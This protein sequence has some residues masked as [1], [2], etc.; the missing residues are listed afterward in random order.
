MVSY[1]VATFIILLNCSRS[2]IKDDRL[3]PFQSICHWGADNQRSG[4]A[5]ADFPSRP[6]L[7]WTYKTTAAV[8]RAITAAD[9]FLFLGTK[10]GRVTVLDVRT[11]KSVRSLS[12]K[13][14]IETTCLIG[15]QYLIVL[16]RTENPT[17]RYINLTSGKTIWK[18][19]AGNIDG[20]P[21]LIRNK[22]IIGNAV[23]QMMAI[24]IQTGD[25]LWEKTINGQI[26]NSMAEYK[27]ALFVA[28]DNGHI[29]SI[30]S[31]NGD[32][33]W[34]NV[35]EKSIAATPVLDDNQMYIG[36]R[37]GTFYALSQSDGTIQWECEAKGGIYQTAAVAENRVYFGTT[38]GVLYCLDCT[39]GSP[40]WQ[41]DTKSVIGTSPLITNQ[42]VI[43]GTLDRILVML[44]R[45][46]GEMVWQMEARG[47]IRTTPLIWKNRLIFASEDRYIYGLGE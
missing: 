29:W 23:G 30:N 20:E 22:M 24:Q 38:Q 15:P 45:I 18:Q 44:N 31:E 16:Q 33:Y 25:I 4:Y 40:V 43:F 9:Q 6:Q 46:T 2:I 47:R 37:E 11:G 35:L 13:K 1:S 36:T 19:N 21:L 7:K 41:Y 10:D 34:N 28:A 42:Q 3:I 27:N 8:G 5:V 26:Y 32:P 14:G 39:D 17:F 12:I